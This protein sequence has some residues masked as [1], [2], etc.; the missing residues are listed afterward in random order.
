MV[1]LLVILLVAFSSIYSQTTEAIN[2]KNQE[3]DQI[4]KSIDTLQT[5][6]EGI[7]KK[8]ESSRELLQKFDRENLLL[9]RAIN[10]LQQQERIK[11]GEIA[12]LTDSVKVINSRISELQKDYAEYIR[13]L[14]MYGKDS[15]FKIIFGSQSLNQA[16]MRYKYF[17]LVSE[18]SV[19]VSDELKSA[20]AEQE[21]LKD[22]LN[23][24]VDYLNNLIGDKEKQ[25]IQITQRKQE[26]EQ[27]LSLLRKDEKNIENE[28]D[29]KR[30]AE[31]VIKNIIVKLEEEER[32]RERR[33]REER[34]KGKENLP[35]REFNYENF[36]DFNELR[37]KLSWPVRSGKVIRSFG[38]NT[39]TKLNTVTLN[40]GID[41]Q[42]SKGT[43][44]RCVAEG[45]ISAIEWIPGYGS[46]VIITHKDKYRTVYGH[47]SDITVNENQKI[48]AGD[49]I[50][51][52]N[53]TLEGSII[54][55]EVWSERNYQDPEVW[56]VRK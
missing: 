12:L 42:T 18:K 21:K 27:L 34:L 28:I 25:K 7:K 29:E 43:E 15:K 52:V 4:H 1:K 3:L 53:A 24:D 16:M 33:R 39:N 31:I 22:L 54:H 40:Y 5:E 41:I 47:I 36:A 20:K 9:N 50:G 11:S 35:V 17:N 13:W 32:E 26:K 10:N 6:L 23:K 46:V 55:F 45:V 37:G 48:N 2:Q 8:A 44:V 38:E 49:I 14:F 19:K 56:L 51:K 30:K